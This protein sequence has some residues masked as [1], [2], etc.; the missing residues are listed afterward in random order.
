MQN[1]E[2]ALKI[3]HF[4]NIFDELDPLFNEG[5]KYKN[6]AIEKIENDEALRKELLDKYFLG[7]LKMMGLSQ[8]STV[9][10]TE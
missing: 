2:E 10:I 5:I 3:C 1:Y 7:L 8:D 9:Q 4:K 6:A